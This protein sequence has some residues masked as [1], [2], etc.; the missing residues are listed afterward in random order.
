M[1]SLANIS[2]AFFLAWTASSAPSLTFLISRTKAIKYSSGEDEIA[3]VDS[4]T[5]IAKISSKNGFL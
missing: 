3:Y 4:P 5:L 1:M 2:T